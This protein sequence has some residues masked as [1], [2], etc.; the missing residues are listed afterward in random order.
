VIIPKSSDIA[1]IPEA[2]F[3]FFDTESGEYRSIVK[4]PIAIEVNPMPKGEELRVFETPQEDVGILHRKEILGRDIIYIKD[5]PGR[6]KPK[7]KFLYKSKLFITLL[8]ILL[9][10]V[11]SV[12]IF[13]RRRDRLQTDIRYARRLRAPRKAKKNLLRVKRLLNSREPDKFFDAV[14]KTLQEYLGDKFHLPTAGITSNIT[15][16]LRTRNIDTEI[17]DK[18]KKCFDMCDVA[19]YAPSSISKEQQQEVFR[20]LVEIIDRLEKVRI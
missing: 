7:G 18:L 4:G 11:V 3:S 10:A 1:D 14:F 6:L 13:Q 9:F 20:L 5:S 2:V 15:E 16:E 12:L 19:R 8:F 17:L